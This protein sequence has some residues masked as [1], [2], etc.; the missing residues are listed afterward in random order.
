MPAY[1]WWRLRGRTVP[2]NLTL[3]KGTRLQ[4]RA[5]NGTDND[6]G[7]AYEVF[8][9]RYYDLPDGFLHESDVR[10]VVD[11]GANVG[12]S[13][14]HWLATYPNARV[15]AYEPHPAFA[16]Q[17]RINLALNNWQSRVEF[18]CAAAGVRAGRAKLSD[19]GTSSRVQSDEVSGIDVAMDD[20]LARASN[21]PIDILKMD[22]EGGEY[23]LLEDDRFSQLAIRALVMEWHASGRKR[24]DGAWCRGRLGQMGYQTS[25]IFEADGHGMLRSRREERIHARDNDSEKSR[26]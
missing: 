11:L 8:V 23:A 25:T 3:A 12:F 19:A 1:A 7:T 22:I 26:S 4:L 2:V 13:C 24:S 6:Y 9:H 17:C 20:F 5:K 21:E 18:H 15:I 16:E 10:L 14:L